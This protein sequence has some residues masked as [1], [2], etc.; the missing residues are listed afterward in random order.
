M[1]ILFHNT[2]ASIS[3]KNYELNIEYVL[4]VTPAVRQNML[5]ELCGSTLSL[6][7]NLNVASTSIIIEPILNITASG[8]CPGIMATKSSIQRGFTCEPGEVLNSNVTTQ[9]KIPV[10]LP[11]PAGSSTSGSKDKCEPCAKGYY[12]RL[13]R[14]PSC[15][16]CPPGTYTYVVF[17]N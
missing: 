4:R 12:Q 2:T 15:E 7:F 11:C 16:K 17:F 6:I 9:T 10:C 8:E 5:Y 3:Q 14:Q 13:T 1:E